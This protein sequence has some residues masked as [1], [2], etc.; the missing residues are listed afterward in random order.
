MWLL[1]LAWAVSL[2]LTAWLT[3]TVA[4]TTRSTSPTPRS[5]SSSG[6]TTPEESAPGEP[7]S[8]KPSFHQ[9]CLEACVPAT[10]M[11]ADAV[12]V[13]RKPAVTHKSTS[14][15]SLCYANTE[16]I[17]DCVRNARHATEAG[18]NQT[19]I[20]VRCA[21]CRHV[22][23]WRKRDGHPKSVPPCVM[24]LMKHFWNRLG[25][26]EGGGRPNRW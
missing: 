18:S 7:P 9:R 19:H 14:R 12:D 10:A 1:L 24:E 8:T 4:R 23:S 13:A 15:R 11:P 6:T 2:A 22:R 25:A 20:W 16:E 21:T 3:W 5:P 26:L 17:E